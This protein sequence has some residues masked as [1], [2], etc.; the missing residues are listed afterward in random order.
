MSAQEVEIRRDRVREGDTTFNDGNKCVLSVDQMVL[1]KL[2]G[3]TIDAATVDG[4]TTLI[5]AE[6]QDSQQRSAP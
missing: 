2:S 3:R 4:K 6:V 5:L 1:R